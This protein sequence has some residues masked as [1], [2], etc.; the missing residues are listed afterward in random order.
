M[1]AKLGLL[2][3]TIYYYRSANFVIKTLIVELKS[4]AECIGPCQSRRGVDELSAFGIEVCVAEERN[5]TCAYRQQSMRALHASKVPR[6]EV[7]LTVRNPSWQLHNSLFLTW[8]AWV[9]EF[10]PYRLRRRGAQLLFHKVVD[11]R[12]MYWK[13]GQRADAL[14]RDR[15]TIYITVA[16]NAVVCCMESLGPK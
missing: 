2:K 1:Q 12:V 10:I 9:F 4:G 8:G 7:W 5:I 11:G 3:R 15:A 16:E 14:G 6:M 13:S